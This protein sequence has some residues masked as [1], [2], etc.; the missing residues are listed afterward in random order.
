MAKQTKLTDDVFRQ[1]PE[2]IAQ[3]LGKNEIAARIGVTPGSLQVKCSQRGVSL[4]KYRPGQLT[5]PGDALPDQALPLSNR[6]LRA[7]Q[8]AAE[9]RGQDAARL[10]GALLEIIAKDDLYSAVL[11]AEAA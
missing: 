5:L 9:A 7:L 4:R 2:L 1:I 6:A 11:D 8:A 3:G 10:A